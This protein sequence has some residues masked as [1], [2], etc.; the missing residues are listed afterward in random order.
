MRT[1]PSISSGARR[2][3]ARAAAALRRVPLVLA[4]AC[5]APPGASAD[6]YTEPIVLFVDPDSAERAR[7]REEHGDEAF[8]II[9]DDAM[10]YRAEALA[11]LDSLGVRH[12]RV[13]RGQAYFRVAGERQ[14]FDWS[15]VEGAWFVV[16]YNGRDE[17]RIARPI[18][19][20]GEV[21]F[22]LPHP[23]IAPTFDEGLWSVK[24]SPPKT[25]PST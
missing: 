7:L 20:R 18:D 13:G 1:E 11:L 8:Y 5:S 3:R 12:E 22:I 24:L 2:M 19:L 17:P 10:W 6:V 9:A 25:R 14:V 15:D 23:K 16:V 21:D 4:A